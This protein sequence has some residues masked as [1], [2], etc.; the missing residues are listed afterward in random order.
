NAWI[1]ETAHRLLW[2]HG[3]RES[4]PAVRELLNSKE[5]L[6]QLH[7]MYSLEGLPNRLTVEELE[8]KVHQPHVG[9]AWNAFRIANSRQLALKIGWGAN[10][11]DPRVLFELC[12]HKPDRIQS[13]GGHLT[14]LL[15]SSDPY[16]AAGGRGIV[17]AT[18]VLTVAALKDPETRDLVASALDGSTASGG[19]NDQEL[20]ALAEIAN[21]E[22]VGVQTKLHI[23][24]AIRVHRR[25]NAVAD[26]K[27]LPVFLSEHRASFRRAM[28]NAALPDSK[29]GNAIRLLGYGTAED[30]DALLAIL[31]PSTSD[32]LQAAAVLSIFKYST[33]TEK[34]HPRDRKIMA[35]IIEIWPTMSPT[36]RK[37]VVS[38]FLSDVLH[39][40]RLLAAIRQGDISGRDLDAESK[41]FLAGHGVSEIA[42][43]ARK[44][45]QPEPTA[46]RKEVLV[47]YRPALDVEGVVAKG[48]ELFLKKCSICH[49][50]G[51]QGH[52]VAPEIVSVVNKSPDDLLIAILDPNRE[53]QPNFTQYTVIT[54][55]GRVY[56][57]MIA[58]ESGV[59]LTLRRAE[60]KQDV[61]RRADIDQ[62]VSTGRSL[63]PEGFEKDLSPEQIRDIIAFV[64]SLGVKQ[65]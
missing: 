14:A 47:K 10:P 60:G 23:A 29:R 3:D 52:L 39:T 42:V 5:P 53:A 65:K 17:L 24:E 8:S 63:M 35:R 27:F 57:G 46:A 20:E 40:R 33:L 36:V 2:E 16:V 32:G 37:S 64:K 50:V 4:E 58:A 13:L 28:R 7:A 9:V 61:I 56:T 45:L 59:S 62:L 38:A 34:Q 48:R 31:S 21:D 19:W 1:R 41:K 12:F 15:R 43:E 18:P 49:K 44:L 26:S 54:K 51:N 25:G 22:N 11:P 30:L 6:A 55:A